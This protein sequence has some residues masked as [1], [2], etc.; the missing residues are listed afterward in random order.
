MVTFL[1][2]K[3]LGKTQIN[4]II[5]FNFISALVLGNFVG[6]AV[7]N[8]EAHVGRIIFVVTE[9]VKDAKNGFERSLLCGLDKGEHLFIRRY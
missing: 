5:P 3:L 1:I 7:Y 2:V 8:K 6:D 9:R 4:Q